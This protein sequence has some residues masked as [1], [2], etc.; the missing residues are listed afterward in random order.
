MDCFLEITGIVGEETW[1][2]HGDGIELLSFWFSVTNSVCAK[3]DPIKEVTLVCS[4]GGKDSYKITMKD[5]LVISLQS[6]REEGAKEPIPIEAVTF[7]YEEI[8]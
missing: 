4:R 7:H 1:P 6:G 3:G 2:P 5:V 8:K